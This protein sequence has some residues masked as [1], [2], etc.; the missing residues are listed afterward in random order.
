MINSVVVAVQNGR[1][2]YDFKRAD[3]YLKALYLPGEGYVFKYRG[4]ASMTKEKLNRFLKASKA[5]MVITGS[6][7]AASSKL[8]SGAGFM[9]ITGVNTDAKEAAANYFEGNVYGGPRCSCG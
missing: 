1:V 5:A 2:A 4:A 3:S 7:D 9:E 8:V 6:I